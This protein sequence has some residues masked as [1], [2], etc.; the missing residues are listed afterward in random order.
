MASDR[1]PSAGR[2]RGLVERVAR[3]AN[4]RNNVLYWAA[5]RLVED[6]YP[7]SAYDEIAM[8]ALNTGLPQWE[9]NKAINSARKALAA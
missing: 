9:V 5:M 6:G 3:E 2:L 7:E 4:E 1:I 8:A